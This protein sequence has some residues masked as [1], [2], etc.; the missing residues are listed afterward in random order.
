MLNLRYKQ[1]GLRPVGAKEE[2]YPYAGYETIYIHRQDVFENWIGYDEATGKIQHYN[3]ATLGVVQEIAT[4]TGE[5]YEIRT[6][7]NFLLLTTSEGL[8]TYLFQ[9][10][11]YNVVSVFGKEGLLSTSFEG[12]NGSGDFAE[13]GGDSADSLL[14][15]YTKAIDEKSEDGQLMGAIAFRVAYKLFDGSFILHTIPDIYQISN[16]ELKIQGFSFV[17]NPYR[18][19]FSGAYGIRAVFDFNENGATGVFDS[20]KTIV[21]SVAIFASPV[22]DFYKIDEDTITE[23]ILPDSGEEVNF[24]DIG[25]VSEKFKNIADQPAWYLLDE[26]SMDLFTQTATPGEYTAE[27]DLDTE[28]YYKNY[29][30]RKTLPIDNYTH[31]QNTG[32]A[33]YIYN[34][35]LILG[36]TR[37]ILADPYIRSLKPYQPKIVNYLTGTSVVYTFNNTT[38][39]YE[40][41]VIV[42]AS[43]SNGEKA[44][45][46]NI[47]LNVYKNPSD[48]TMKAVFFDPIVGYYDDR[49]TF[50]QVL[51]KINDKY[52]SIFEKNLESS[53]YSN[54][55]V[56]NSPYF[57]PKLTEKISSISSSDYSRNFRH[58]QITFDVDLL[59]TP[60]TIPSEDNAVSD[61][62]N[63]K[64]SEVSNPLQFNITNNFQVG[65]GKI[66]AYG[67]NT[68]P[69]SD[70]QFG[71][72][73][74]YAFTTHGI[75][76]LQIGLGDVFI[77]RIDPVSGEVILNKD[78]KADV[79][80]GTVYAT[81][82]GLKLIS[83]RKVVEISETVEGIPTPEIQKN[84]RYQ[85][86]TSLEQTA[87][88]SPYIDTVPLKE[89]LSNAIIGYNK[90]IDNEEI[91]VSNKDYEYSYIFDLKHKRWFKT[92]QV[93]ERFINYYPQLYGMVRP[94][95][96]VTN[97]LVNGDFEGEWSTN[98]IPY[99]WVGFA[100]KMVREVVD[101][102]VRAKFPGINYIGVITLHQYVDNLLEGDI[103]TLKFD[104]YFTGPAATPVTLRLDLVLNS[105]INYDGSQWL[106]A[107]AAFEYIT[108]TEEGEG[109]Y[110]V[111]LPALPEGGTLD[112]AFFNEEQDIEYSID[113]VKLYKDNDT[114]GK[115]VN[116]SN[117]VNSNVKCF[118][119]TRP[120]SM[121]GVDE[122]IKLHRTMLR[123]YLNT[124]AGKY[125][126]VYLFGSDDLIEWKFITG[127]DRNTG[128][129]KDVW[130]S[131]SNN[132]SKFYIIVFIAE[133]EYD[134]T[135]YDNHIKFIES[136]VVKKWS[137]KL[138]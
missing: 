68:D 71:Q 79:S 86:F 28:G 93:Y 130:V 34:D 138:R 13:Q 64:V 50:L 102:N 66:L 84:A 94:K 30:S 27:K 80:F 56:Y 113:N 22:T 136:E 32:E 44:M 42:K 4:I 47:S 40:G 117:E 15:A 78:S 75:Y 11:K 128:L 133:L 21:T 97:L 23:D 83:G 105:T 92:S 49:S 10:D 45:I 55:S 104:Y 72:Y 98:N 106:N 118:F 111:T 38:D 37:Q 122:F 88:V 110:E 95:S 90:S 17:E 124:A 16:Y 39:I 103:C 52:Y 57:D 41:K 121:A 61:E 31:H 54:F 43:T 9:D 125:A 134:Q 131:H 29:A 114:P 129:F 19:V 6:L 33:T 123:A 99:G 18:W 76:A 24:K 115:V 112:V 60:I 96:P 127:N 116:L 132:S 7:K 74:I 12:I 59:T 63:G 69:I 137:S 5:I 89:Y 58:L 119:Q 1:G 35:R 126:A 48:Y 85:F 135:R 2:L 101:G 51:I 3:P 25:E 100:N 73:P 26:V 62:N 70:S 36:A 77:P 8:L 109:T 107:P 91:V 20:L 14:A 108:L 120:Q 87:D 65:E 81:L 53:T 82:E 67:T 46:K